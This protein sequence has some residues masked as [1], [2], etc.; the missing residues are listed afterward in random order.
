[1]AEPCAVPPI[2]P[3]PIR[4]A[5]GTAIAAAAVTGAGRRTSKGSCWTVAATISGGIAALC[6]LPTASRP[7]PF[8]P[9]RS[10][11]GSG[12]GGSKQKYKATTP[13]HPLIPEDRSEPVWLVQLDCSRNE[14]VMNRS[15]PFR[16]RCYAP[17]SML[18]PGEA[19]TPP[20]S[21]AAELRATR[22]MICIRDGGIAEP[23]VREIAP[24]CRDGSGNS[25]SPARN[26]R[27]AA[28]S[29][30]SGCR[31]RCWRRRGVRP[32]FRGRSQGP[33][34]GSAQGA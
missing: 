22:I 15:S 29:T 24:A 8:P 13:C 33:A 1:M 28:A 4:L 27:G 5:S 31:S 19:R 23:L 17:E 21:A 10:E 2:R 3:A 14:P 34:A 9:C 32:P 7:V 11:G 18:L 30:S 6:R 25:H 20:A 26:S 16:Q 12:E